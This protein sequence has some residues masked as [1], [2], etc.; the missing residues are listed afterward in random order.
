MMIA[1]E[2]KRANLVKKRSLILAAI[3]AKIGKTKRSIR[4]NPK[5]NPIKN[6]TKRVIKSKRCKNSKKYYKQQ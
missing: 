2:K 1:M 5:R 6:L 3:I 4:K